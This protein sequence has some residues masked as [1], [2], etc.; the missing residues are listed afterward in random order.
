MDRSEPARAAKPS[1]PGRKAPP[2]S[3][4]DQDESST[5]ATN[6]DATPPQRHTQWIAPVALPVAPSTWSEA[7]QVH[8]AVGG[9]CAQ[10]SHNF[11][12]IFGSNN[13]EYVAIKTLEDDDQSVVS[14]MPR[15]ASCSAEF[16]SNDKEH[17]AS[18]Y[19]RRKCKFV[20]IAAVTLAMFIALVGDRGRMRADLAAGDQAPAFTAMTSANVP[21]SSRQGKRH[22]STP[23]PLPTRSRR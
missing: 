16:V 17:L 7:A 4:I 9:K 20:V 3:A 6:R 21:P 1:R 10:P 14:F 19:A 12:M 23:P 8:L 15:R 2:S 5:L 18:S 11:A 13:S 22:T